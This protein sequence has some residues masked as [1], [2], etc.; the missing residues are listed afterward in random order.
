MTSIFRKI[1]YRKFKVQK[2]LKYFM[3]GSLNHN[4]FTFIVAQFIAGSM[5]ISG[6]EIVETYAILKYMCAFVKAAISHILILGFIAK[7]I[8]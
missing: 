8:E 1:Y 2:A 7:I 6:F 4:S 5:K 3:T